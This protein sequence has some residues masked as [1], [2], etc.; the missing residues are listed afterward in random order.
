MKLP[1][2]HMKPASKAHL[3]VRCCWAR[4][5]ASLRVSWGCRLHPRTCQRWGQRWDP[6]VIGESMRALALWSGAGWCD[7]GWQQGWNAQCNPRKSWKRLRVSSFGGPLM[8]FLVYPVRTHNFSL[9]WQHRLWLDGL[10]GMVTFLGCKCPEPTTGPMRHMSY[11]EPP[12]S[13]GTPAASRFHW[14]NS[15]LDEKWEDRFFW[16]VQRSTFGCMQEPQ[17]CL[18]MQ[19]CGYP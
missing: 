14:C 3:Q 8:H 2:N 10:A 19:M 5:C 7:G 13:C 12:W 4:H 15:P 6:R 9:L 17:A 1:W 18:L 11:I 16:V